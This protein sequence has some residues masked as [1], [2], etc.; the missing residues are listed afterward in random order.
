MPVG[1]D[2]EE[3]RQ[4]IAAFTEATKC[5]AQA[6]EGE[7]TRLP[8]NSFQWRQYRQATKC[9]LAA[10]ANSLRHCLPAQWSFK[11]L[12]PPNLLEPAG[13]QGVREKLLDEEAKMFGVADDRKLFFRY[14]FDSH[15]ACPDFFIHEDFYGLIF[16]ADEGT[17]VP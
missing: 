10:F 15:E 14:S 8:A 2:P 4:A 11:S 3:C 7:K 5:H 1:P 17:E 9:L 13:R 16:S 6:A 12:L